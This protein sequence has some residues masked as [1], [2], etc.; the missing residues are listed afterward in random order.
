V[1]QIRLIR[2]IC[3]QNKKFLRIYGSI[4]GEVTT[5]DSMSS[6]GTKHKNEQNIFADL[7]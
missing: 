3:G 7:I 4:K 6:V 1:N 5:T 2:A